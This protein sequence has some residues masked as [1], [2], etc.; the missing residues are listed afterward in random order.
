MNEPDHYDEMLCGIADKHK[1]AWKQAQMRAHSM[2]LSPHNV[3]RIDG[4][5]IDQMRQRQNADQDALVAKDR[6]ME[7]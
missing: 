7:P 2:G 3:Q 5:P 6:S 1:I 4:E